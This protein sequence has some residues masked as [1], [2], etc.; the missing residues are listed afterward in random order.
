MQAF[1][2]I[3]AVIMAAVATVSATAEARPGLTSTIANATGS[4]HVRV[5]RWGGRVSDGP[6]RGRAPGH[7]DSVHIH[8]TERELGYRVR[9]QLEPRRKRVE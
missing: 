5:T 9:A 4:N 2:I 6:G 8:N 3:V 1:S 7:Q